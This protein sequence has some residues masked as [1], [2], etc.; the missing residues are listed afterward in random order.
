MD[1][2]S[3]LRNDPY[4]HTSSG[5]FPRPRFPWGVDG[6]FR[7]DVSI[8]TGRLE[9]GRESHRI[10]WRTQE[11]GRLWCRANGPIPSI[12]QTGHEIA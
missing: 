3:R 5:T 6:E 9:S 1:A 2:R 8:T 4:R 7:F 11:G 10:S 12:V